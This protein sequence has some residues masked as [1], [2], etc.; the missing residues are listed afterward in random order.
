MEMKGP[1]FAHVKNM[2]AVR[3]ASGIFDQTAVEEP[4]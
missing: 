3:L 4:F 2:C 1:K